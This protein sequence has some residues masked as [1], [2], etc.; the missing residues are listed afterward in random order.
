MLNVKYDSNT[1]EVIEENAH[2][3]WWLCTI[4]K[5][6][7]LL[8]ENELTDTNEN[9]YCDKTDENVPREMTEIPAS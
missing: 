2:W 9:S 4:L 6:L 5:I 8:P 1:D 3:E 7:N